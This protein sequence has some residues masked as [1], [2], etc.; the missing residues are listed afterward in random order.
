MEYKKK[1]YRK[2][3]YRGMVYRNTTLFGWHGITFTLPAEVIDYHPKLSD[4]DTQLTYFKA[5]FSICCMTFLNI[6]N[7][8]IWKHWPFSVIH[9]HHFSHLLVY[10][11]KWTFVDICVAFCTI[12]L[13]SN[14]PQITHANHM[15]MTT[16]GQF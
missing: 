11:E 9:D 6:L 16:S 10:M 2:R 8:I 12:F 4:I 3:T 13:R 7:H 1:H 14:S 5:T 15:T